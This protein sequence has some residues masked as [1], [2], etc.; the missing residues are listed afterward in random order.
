M[1]EDL[2]MAR[3]VR[4]TFRETRNFLTASFRFSATVPSTFSTRL[5]VTRFVWWP[6]S[7]YPSS[8][9]Y[10]HNINIVQQRPSRMSYL[11]QVASGFPGLLSRVTRLVPQGYKNALTWCSYVFKSAPPFFR[12]ER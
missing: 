8:L 6:G 9:R 12:Q 1:S 5:A 2:P 7:D 11:F 3:L 10:L 4:L